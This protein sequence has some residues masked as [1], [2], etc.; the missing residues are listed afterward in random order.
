MCR[1]FV[2]TD[3]RYWQFISVVDSDPILL[4]A[5]TCLLYT[6]VCGPRLSFVSSSG[7]THLASLVANQGMTQRDAFWLQGV[8]VSLSGDSLRFLWRSWRADDARADLRWELRRVLPTV[9][10]L[11]TSKNTRLCIVAAAQESRWRGW[12]SAIGLDP[13]EHWGRSTHSLAKRRRSFHE[14]VQAEESFWMSTEGLLLCLSCWV[15]FRKHIRSQLLVRLVLQTFLRA[16]CDVDVLRRVDFK[17]VPED[18]LTACQ[19]VQ[20]VGRGCF[21]WREWHK[22]VV[23][24]GGEDVCAILSEALYTLAVHMSCPLC[25][26]FFGRLVHTIA[27]HIQER[28]DEWHERDLKDNASCI[29][30]EGPAGNKRRRV[31]PWVREAVVAATNVHSSSQGS[32]ALIRADSVLSTTV[33]DKWAIGWLAQMQTQC[34]LAAKRSMVFSSAFDASY[35]GE[36]AQDLLLHCCWAEGLQR[37]LPVPPV[38]FRR[39]GK[40]YQ[41][42]QS[43][44]STSLTRAPSQLGLRKNPIFIG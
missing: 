20:L 38:V 16:T 4:V 14:L 25:T 15:T 41:P 8:G 32:G 2:R 3:I 29:W 19:N 10:Y 12:M 13:E 26:R 30:L 9:G 44:R 33:L 39:R 36:P 5:N 6:D 43:R 27:C 1:I 24:F 34:H 17:A 11:E 40:H 21:C 42:K 23:N 37:L 22:R 35:I 28:A 31:D 18:L 7:P